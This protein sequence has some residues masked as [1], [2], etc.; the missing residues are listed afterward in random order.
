MIG[1]GPGPWNV[2]VGV[3]LQFDGG[4]LCVRFC[5]EE[6]PSGLCA[7][8]ERGGEEGGERVREEGVYFGGVQ[9]WLVGGVGIWHSF[10]SEQRWLGRR[11]RLTLRV[12]SRMSTTTLCMS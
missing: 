4:R 11:N 7:L 8:G 9:H 1:I 10:G 3:V 2:G 6:G 12:L 5:F